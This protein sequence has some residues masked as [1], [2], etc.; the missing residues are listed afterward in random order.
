LDFFEQHCQQ[1]NKIVK[2][3]Y[4]W[5]NHPA[6]MNL[7]RRYMHLKL[8]WLPLNYMYPYIWIHAQYFMHILFLCCIVHTQY[9]Y[10]GVKWLWV[11]IYSYWIRTQKQPLKEIFPLTSRYAHHVQIQVALIWSYPFHRSHFFTFIS[12]L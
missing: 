3:N 9:I 8:P 5:L 11:L 1:I 6:T 7:S 2:Q 12:R 4:H 10:P